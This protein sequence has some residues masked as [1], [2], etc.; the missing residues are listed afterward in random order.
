M[1]SPSFRLVD[2]ST[3]RDSLLEI[4]KLIRK[5]SINK[6]ILLASKRLTRDCA[7]RDDMC[8]LESIFNAVKY[9]DSR[10]PW[11]K[12]GIRYVADPHSYDTFHAVDSIIEFA[13]NGSGAFDCDDVTIL[14][15]S[16][17]ASLGF[18]VGA[19]AWGH[20]SNQNGDYQHIYA[21]ACI[22]KNGPWP[23]D[24]YGHGLDTT[25]EQSYV[26]WEPPGG[27]IMTAWP[28]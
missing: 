2:V 24:Y 22:P 10:V 16:L 9:G 26:G 12:R 3:Q 27:H 20:G 5:G 17:A 7:A 19:R 8:E 23:V 11:L 21:I 13:K 6:D 18:Q 4:E 28:E 1:P 14:I 25:A 15:G